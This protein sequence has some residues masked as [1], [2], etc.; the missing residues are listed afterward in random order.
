MYSNINILELLRI[1]P[2]LVEVPP[3]HFHPV[4]IDQVELQPSPPPSDQN[5]V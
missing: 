1:G 5:L 4:S 3:D 2:E